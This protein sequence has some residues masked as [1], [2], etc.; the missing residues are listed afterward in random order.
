MLKKK[1][2]KKTEHIFF[3]QENTSDAMAYMLH[4]EFKIAYN[5]YLF[6]FNFN[7]LK[8]LFFLWIYVLWHVSIGKGSAI[9]HIFSL[10]VLFF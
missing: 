7:I 1:K 2:K 5:R 8:K 6:I 4:T 3:F 10:F 9:T